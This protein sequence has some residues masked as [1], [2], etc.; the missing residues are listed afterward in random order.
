MTIF[1]TYPEPTPWCPPPLLG[2]RTLDLVGRPARCP[3]GDDHD[4]S[5]VG[6]AATGTGNPGRSAAHR[7]G[8]GT[9][10]AP[11]G[12]RRTMIGVRP[13][14]R[15]ARRGKTVVDVVG[16]RRLRPAAGTPHPPREAADGAEERDPARRPQARGG[17]G[18][19]VRGTATA[20]T[21]LSTRPQGARR[22]PARAF[23]RHPNGAR[24]AP[25]GAAGPFRE[26][27]LSDVGRR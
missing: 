5:L 8:R 21:E 16:E 24:T 6:G 20:P 15:R 18:R 2:S 7:R 3:G 9:K 25:A 19:H 22:R 11:S 4:R 17:N 10:P 27:D 14:G 12:R 1:Y 23:A 13:G 26:D